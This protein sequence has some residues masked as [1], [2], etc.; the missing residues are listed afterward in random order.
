MMKLCHQ[1][2]FLAI[3]LFFFSISEAARSTSSKHGLLSIILGSGGHHG[4][5]IFNF[6]LRIL[7]KVS[8]QRV[9]ALGDHPATLCRGLIFFEAF[10]FHYWFSKIKDKFFDPFNYSYREKSSNKASHV[11][12]IYYYDSPICR[13]KRAI[14]PKC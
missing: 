1:I 7:Y 5:K 2:S 8:V 10:F 6:R 12:Q 13:D 4:G 9:L 14:T 3:L 11:A